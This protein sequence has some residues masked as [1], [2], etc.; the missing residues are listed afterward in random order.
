MCLS[1]SGLYACASAIGGWVLMTIKQQ[2][3]GGALPAAR[4]RLQSPLWSAWLLA[5]HALQPWL[6]PQQQ[7]ALVH[8]VQR[9]SLL[10]DCP[11]AISWTGGCATNDSFTA[12]TRASVDTLLAL[13]QCHVSELLIDHT[14]LTLQWACLTGPQPGD[15][16]AVL[17]AF[18]V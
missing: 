3:A 17:H 12:V 2:P 4:W 1:A 13:G 11:L 5:R 16:T 8:Q 7:P 9:S 14:V 10:R 6:P 18:A 15:C